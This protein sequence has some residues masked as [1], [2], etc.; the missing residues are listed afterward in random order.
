MSFDVESI[1]AVGT[2]HLGCYDCYLYRS[3]CLIDSSALSPNPH[4]GPVKPAAAPERRASLA[5]TMG[6]AMGIST[7]S[8]N[9][10]SFL[11]SSRFGSMQ[12]NNIAALSVVN[13]GGNSAYKSLNTLRN[14]LVESCLVA[15]CDM[16]DA[17]SVKMGNTSTPQD[18]CDLHPISGH[19]LHCCKE[20]IS[21]RN[22]YARIYGFAVSKVY[23]W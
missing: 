15:I 4:A 9:S 5:V 17:I 20:I 19:V 22:I 6:K 21:H 11:G 10:N 12:G 14:S 16:G 8:T 7:A 2:N 1:F 18:T 3:K 23:L 13:I